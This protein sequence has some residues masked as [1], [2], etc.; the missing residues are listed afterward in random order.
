MLASLVGFAAAMRALCGSLY[1]ASDRT[2]AMA[3]LMALAIV[4]VFF[5]P[6]SR[7][8]YDFTTLWSFALGL[9]LMAQ[10]RWP[11]YFVLFAV[12]TVNKE[13]S[14]LLMLVF[15]AH[16]IRDRR[17]PLP[18]L[19]RRLLI[20]A[21]IFIVI[22]GVIAFVFRNNAGGV[23]EINWANHNQQVLM[24]PSMMARRLPLLI[25]A[26]GVG[27]WG[28][29]HK[30]PLLRDAFVVLAPVL[31]VMGV[32]VGQVDEIRAYYEIYPVVVLM[33]TDTVS[34]IGGR[35][36]LARPLLSRGAA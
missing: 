19:I 21:A 23:V 7:Q 3:A 22:R 1:D 26:A 16:F 28:W 12:A 11:A 4:P 8:I 6:F 9:L 36:L 20:Q 34:R 17:M 32:T 14:V 2:A 35:A 29:R 33:V 31:L 27:M 5:G 15:A 24:H 25:A 30:A 13:T 10:R 18:D